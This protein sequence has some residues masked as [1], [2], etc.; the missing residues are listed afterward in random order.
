MGFT[1]FLF[2]CLINGRHGSST[3]DF[4][5]LV[6]YLCVPNVMPRHCMFML[7]LHSTSVLVTLLNGYYSLGCCPLRILSYFEDR[8]GLF[9]QVVLLMFRSSWITYAD[10][11]KELTFAV[12]LLLGYNGRWTALLY[13]LL[14]KT[15]LQMHVANDDS[16]YWHWHSGSSLQKYCQ[17]ELLRK[18]YFI[19]HVEHTFVKYF[20]FCI[21]WKY[22]QKEV[23][24]PITDHFSQI[25]SCQSQAFKLFRSIYNC[26]SAYTSYATGAS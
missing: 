2:S 14:W 20:L 16:V 7:M 17:K 10:F 18:Y 11:A 15:Q 25:H 22:L 4:C 23:F 5:L 8:L 1:F 19:L 21:F 3:P 24:L 13:L 6:S 9:L 26:L 12:K